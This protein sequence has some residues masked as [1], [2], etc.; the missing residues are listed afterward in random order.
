MELGLGLELSCRFEG[1][2]ELA[3]DLG[4]ECLQEALDTSSLRVDVFLLDEDLS[5]G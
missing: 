5:R 3:R 2:C 4:A 1:D